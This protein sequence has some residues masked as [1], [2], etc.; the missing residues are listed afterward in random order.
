MKGLVLLL[1]LSFIFLNVSAQE[2]G[3][4]IITYKY[5]TISCTIK[6]VENGTVYYSI[7][8]NGNPDNKVLHYKCISKAVVNQNG[9]LCSKKWC[10]ES[11]TPKK[12]VRIGI[13]GGYSEVFT[14]VP[15]GLNEFT[16]DYLLNLNT[17]FSVGSDFAYLLGQN[18]GLFFKINIFKS[19]M[20]PVPIIVEYDN[21]ITRQ[22]SLSDNISIIYLALGPTFR[23]NLKYDQGSFYFNPGIGIQFYRNKSKVIDE[24]LTKG[25]TLGIG[26]DVGYDKNISKNL[27]I[28]F[29]VSYTLG[30]LKEVTITG[31]NYE[32]HYQFNEL[33]YSNIT[34]FDV[35]ISLRFRK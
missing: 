24:F 22:G 11:L 14:E 18:N 9:N 15:D 26:F 8:E 25:N 12:R 29:N 17:G 2:H 34:R 10:L 23:L 35:G 1:V 7:T 5:D 19:W 21:G 3:D 6:K 30:F 20:K 16:K 32:E 28:G 13:N 4:C 27:G 33:K 31:D